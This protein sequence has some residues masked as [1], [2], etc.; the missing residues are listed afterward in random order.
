MTPK[1]IKVKAV[2]GSFVY[3]GK[4][5]HDAVLYGYS[6]LLIVPVPNGIL[7]CNYLGQFQVAFHLRKKDSWWRRFLMFVGV[8]PVFEF[9]RL[10]M[11][12]F[13]IGF[14]NSVEEFWGAVWLDYGDR[15]NRYSPNQQEIIK[16]L[17]SLGE[18]EYA[19]A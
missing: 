4:K 6:S 12:L 1:N 8:T 2:D 18:E 13:E 15:I 14:N 19:L 9:T 10:G 16:T 17:S 3:K 11:W 5:Y 7:A